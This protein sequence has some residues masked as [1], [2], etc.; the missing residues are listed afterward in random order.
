MSALIKHNQSAFI[1]RKSIHDNF[2]AVQLACRWLYSRRCPIILLKIDI[3]KAFDSVS[4]E[5]LIQLLTFID[6]LAR[7]TEWIA[8]LLSTATTRVVVNGRPSRRIYHVRVLWQGDPLSPML[9]I[10]IMEVLNNMI[11]VT[12]RHGVL[13]PL[14]SATIRNRA[15]LY[16]DDLSR[17]SLAQGC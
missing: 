14:P 13:L 10:V 17:L 5:F 9:F 15:S 8:I 6:F 3:A 11:S 16:V 1:Q 2:M 12:D 7:W 4:W